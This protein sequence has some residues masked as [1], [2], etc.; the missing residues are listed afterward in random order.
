MTAW[1]HAGATTAA[2]IAWTVGSAA[3]ISA[4]LFLVFGIAACQVL[5]G[6]KFKQD[7]LL[8]SRTKTD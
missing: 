6:M 8:Y 1:C 4:L 3:W 7:S 2:A 5:A